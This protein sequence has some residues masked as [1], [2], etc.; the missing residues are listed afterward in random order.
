[1]P[2]PMLPGQ[3]APKVGNKGQNQVELPPQLKETKGKD[4]STIMEELNKCPFFMTEYDDQ[5]GENET[6]E[7]L[8]A[9]AFEGEPEEVAT[10]FKNQGND[11]F[12][13]KQYKGAV[14][15]YTKAIAAKS[16]I[17]DLETKVY[18][19]RAQC[20]LMLRNYRSCINDCKKTLELDPK[21]VKAY[22]KM[23]KCFIQLRKYQDAIDAINFG[24]KFKPGDKDFLSLLGE[25]A[26]KLEQEHVKLEREL[27]EK[28]AL[29]KAVEL[30]QLCLTF[31]KEGSQKYKKFR[32]EDKYE[33]ES[34][35]IFGCS[36]EFPSLDS[37]AFL[38]QVG[39]LSSI[40]DIIQIPITQKADEQ[41]IDP[42]PSLDQWCVYMETVSG[43]LVKVG[44]KKTIHDII[45]SKN[46]PVPI[47]DWI[48][49][50]Y[51]LP[52]TQQDADT[53]ISK[54]D[55]KDRIHMRLKDNDLE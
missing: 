38:E 4:N 17:T 32:L 26:K 22:F 50:L 1:M 37:F 11:L 44:Q 20:N 24:L 16:G 8:K 55:K 15:Y 47:I 3:E 21:F 18:S 33:Y 27:K 54:W 13:V 34:Q 2:A 39:E 23:A 6:L 12:K 53:F 45:T 19:N 49:K 7:A 28:E 25:T 40:A 46:V 36:V 52:K 30:R 5:D 35:L 14:D 29:E 48:I 42:E 51:V 10:N 43:G 31:T 9:L 41:Q